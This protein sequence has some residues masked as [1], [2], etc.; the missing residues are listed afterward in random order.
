MPQPLR[1][2]LL[3]L[4]ALGILGL[5]G[6]VFVRA[7]RRSED[8]TRM[9]VRWLITFLIVGWVFYEARKAQGAEKFG[10][11]FF[12]ALPSAVVLTILW[13]R[14][15]GEFVAR[16]FSNLFSGG[17]EEP[18]PVP[19]YSTAEALRKRGKCREAVYAIQEQLEKFPNDFIGQMM[20]A[21]IQ[22]ENLNDLQAAETTVLRFC[23]QPKHSPSNLAFALNSLADWHLK[24][25]QDPEPARQA[26]EK[27]IELLPATEFE[28]TAANR[29]A[30]LATTEQLVHA[31][32]PATVKMKQ[33]VEYLG[34]L[35]SQ[36]HLLPKEKGFKDEAAELVAHLDAHPMDNEARER[37]AIIYAREYGRLD[38]ATDQF[39][40]LIA[41][42][43]ESPKH[44]ARW[45]NLLA[46]LQVEATNKTE[47]AE[48]TLRRIVE[49]F[50]NQSHAQIAEARL[51]SLALELK[52]FEKSRVV[53]FSPTEV[54]P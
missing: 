7:V 52:R 27:I 33:G 2:A 4:A 17:D 10:V 20:L 9:I 14:T 34:L 48:Q 36:E 25:G 45:L 24:F 18:D 47:L 3:A 54:E 49:L 46:D 43:N 11:L 26:L 13:G 15:I 50:P 30:H 12:V 8:P 42:P 39:E 53:K 6:F 32:E 22:A 41:L 23:T 28:R 37:L 16:P 19:L 35:K 44:I 21:E 40:Q 38:L 29:I 5:I 51:A 31:H 1:I